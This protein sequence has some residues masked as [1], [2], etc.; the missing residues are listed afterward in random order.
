MIM[1][2]K[3]NIS[4]FEKAEKE[5]KFNLNLITLENFSN[6]KKE[7]IRYVTNDEKEC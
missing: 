2:S 6:I 5:I 4:E 3:Q 7:L 1:G